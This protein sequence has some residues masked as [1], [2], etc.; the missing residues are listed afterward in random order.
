MGIKSWN[1]LIWRE[2]SLTSCYQMAFLWLRE[3]NQQYLLLTTSNPSKW[4]IFTTTWKFAHYQGVVFFPHR[5]REGGVLIF[6]PDVVSFCLSDYIFPWIVPLSS[7]AYN[8]VRYLFILF[9][10]LQTLFPVFTAN[11]PKIRSTHLQQKQAHWRQSV[12]RR[13]RLWRTTAKIYRCGLLF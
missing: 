9:F 7:S 13:I 4:G 11:F 3:A 6:V 12:R 1:K 2:H 8:A 5:K 10:I